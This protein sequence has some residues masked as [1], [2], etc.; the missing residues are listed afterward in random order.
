MKRQ[1]EPS[2][3][4]LLAAVISGEAR[5]LTATWTEP[6]SEQVAAAAARLRAVAHGRDD[7]LAERAGVLIGFYGDDPLEPER[8]RAR[9]A[10]RCL[11]A[12]MSEPDEKLVMQ[13][14]ETGQ[15]RR[16]QADTPPAQHPPGG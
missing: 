6:D 16:R 2:G 1:W 5:N 11:L 7:L 10:A 13:W 3:D 4:R 12:A 15:Q 8:A 9:A 14:I